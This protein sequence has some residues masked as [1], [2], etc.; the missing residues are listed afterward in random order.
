MRKDKKIII[1]IVRQNLEIKTELIWISTIAS[2]DT[3]FIV[4]IEIDKVTVAIETVHGKLHRFFFDLGTWKKVNY[5]W[6]GVL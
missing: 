4:T 2:T 1:T 5:S 6:E 3:Y